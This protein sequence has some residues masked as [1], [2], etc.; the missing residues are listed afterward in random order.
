MLYDIAIWV[1][2]IALHQ[3][4]D[5]DRD[6]MNTIAIP[7]QLLSTSDFIMMINCTLIIG[8]WMTNASKADS[9]VY[10]IHYT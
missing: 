1:N 10:G 9:K 4:S 5:I 3:L 6:K 8:E 7:H 2:I